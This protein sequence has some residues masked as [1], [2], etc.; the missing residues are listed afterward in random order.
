ML[1]ARWVVS[2]PLSSEIAFASDFAVS[3]GLRFSLGLRAVLKK[4]RPLSSVLLVPRGPLDDGAELVEETP[5]LEDLRLVIEE[6]LLELRPA[7]LSSTALPDLPS[8][9]LAALSLEEAPPWLTF[10]SDTALAREDSRL[11]L[12]SA[13]RVLSPA[14]FFSLPSLVDA[15]FWGCEVCGEPLFL[16]CASGCNDSVVCEDV[17]LEGVAV[18]EEPP[19]LVLGGAELLSLGFD[20]DTALLD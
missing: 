7:G 5:T 14:E 11:V 10:L 20:A 2:P 8:A 13:T 17:F 3:P 15:L 1:A 16:C 9:R 4:D 18:L 6:L 19:L 12:L